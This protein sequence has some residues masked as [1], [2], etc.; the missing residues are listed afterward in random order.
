MHDWNEVADGVLARR[1]DELDLTVGLILGED[2]ALIVDTRGD[3]SQGAEFANAVREVTTLPWQV[4]ITHGHFDHC[5][6]TTAFLPAPV[7]AQRYCGAYLNATAEQQREEWLEHY[8]D[9]PIATALAATEVAMP[10]RPVDSETELDLGGRGVRLLHLGAGHTDHDLVVQVPDVSV[11]FAGDLVE[12][13]AAPDFGDA[14]PTQWPST[15]DK[16]LRLSPNIVIPGHGDPVGP[17]FV[18]TQRAEIA[19]IAELC[20]A[21][22]GGSITAREAVRRSPYPVSTTIAALRAS[23]RA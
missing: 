2:Y 12:Q 10:D 15:L 17:E 22:S 5:F 9:S 20:T 16:L 3:G 21:V 23:N 19:D 1:Y 14:R 18:E 4:A 6:G 11:V 8:R 7:W 13:A